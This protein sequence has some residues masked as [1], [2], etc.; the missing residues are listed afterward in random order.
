MISPPLRRLVAANRVEAL[1]V[2]GFRRLRLLPGPAPGGRL[3]DRGTVEQGDLHPL[4]PLALPERHRQAAHQPRLQLVR[5]AELGQK[6]RRETF[7]LPRVLVV[8]DEVVQG[9]QAVLEG[10]GGGAARALL[11]DRPLGA[12]AV[13]AGGFDL[14][15]AAG[16]GLTSV[17]GGHGGGPCSDVEDHTT[18]KPLF[19]V[20]C[21]AVVLE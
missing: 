6:A 18:S 7:K 1:D 19:L 9:G 10:T 12:G 16:A 8:E 13:A 14:G 2:E 17:D 21:S 20:S 4:G 5:G 3:H 15:G 11:G